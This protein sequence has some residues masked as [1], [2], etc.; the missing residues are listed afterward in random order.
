MP[1]VEAPFFCSELDERVHLDV[2]RLRRGVAG[3]AFT[4]PSRPLAIFQPALSG[5]SCVPDAL[6]FSPGIPRITLDSGI[7][8]CRRQSTSTS[9][10][11]RD[12]Q[13]GWLVF[14]GDPA[15]YAP[16]LLCRGCLMQSSNSLG[17]SLA[18]NAAL[19]LESA[20][21]SL[22]LTVRKAS[23]SIGGLNRSLRDAIED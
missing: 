19:A 20:S 8:P 6:R 21:P 18:M 4:G 11:M 2:P 3:I 7:V 9:S 14:G 17:H 22:L 1:R 15:T 23:I 5:V 10:G 13:L 12:F 16:S